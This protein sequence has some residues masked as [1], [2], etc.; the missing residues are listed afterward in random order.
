MYRA[1]C[2]SLYETILEEIMAAWKKITVLLVITFAGMNLFAQENGF[3]FKSL[4]GGGGGTGTFTF[5]RSGYEL[6][7]YGEYAFLFYEKGIQ[8]SNHI[9]GK[10]S[11][12]TTGS[13]NNYGTG[14]TMEKISFG[15]FLP[16]DFLRSYAFIEG[17]V[18][19][20]G[21]NKTISLVLMFGGG[22]GIDLFFHKN[23]SIYLEAGYLQHYLNNELVGGVSISIGTRGWLFK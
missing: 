11:S 3:T 20:G 1:F 4:F 8:I 15:G 2:S 22:G 7:G 16:K 23:G 10:G 19:F 21:N 12:I 17:G 5:D 18:G 6:G 14:A 13:E 9:I